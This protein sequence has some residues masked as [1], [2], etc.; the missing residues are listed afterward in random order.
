MPRFLVFGGIILA[1]LF[2]A[3]RGP[4]GERIRSLGWDWQG[5]QLLVWDA[6]QPIFR[7]EDTYE[8]AA[9]LAAKEFSQK[10]GVEVSIEFRGRDEIR[11]FLSGKSR[12]KETPDIC[13]STEWPFCPEDYCVLDQG[14]SDKFLE[15]AR[16]Y[17]QIGLGMAG[18]PSFFFPVGA[19]LRN[20]VGL[21][22]P[23]LLNRLKGKTEV[24]IES[25]AFWELL[26]SSP[27]SPD[28]SQMALTFREILSLAPESPAGSVLEAWLRGS[29]D[30][31]FP[32]TPYL[33]RWIEG[34][35][36]ET[37]FL[38]SSAVMSGKEFYTVP[39]FVVTTRDPSKRECAAEFAAVLAGCL[40]R[41]TARNLNA[42]PALASD[43][44]VFLSEASLSQEEKLWMAKAAR[45]GQRKLRA[46]D[47]HL[48]FERFYRYMGE[49]IKDKSVSKLKAMSLEELTGVFQKALGA[50]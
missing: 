19:T 48:A 32:A 30:G 41:W 50:K 23:D 35:G 7:E 4:A 22:A 42:V 3:C 40:G 26:F 25:M 38:P 37:R 21:D 20:T 39:G 28:P 12:P 27:G 49:W 18:V 13:Y 24:E 8:E 47:S 15:A 6:R 34:N 11:D 2:S 17:W 29:V 33:T 31:L 10:Y 16:L 5:K 46:V 45:E 36:S 44:A 9:E 43:Y 14:T 1:F